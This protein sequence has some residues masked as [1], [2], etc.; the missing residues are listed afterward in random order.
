M[1]ELPF[2]G[3]V[4]Y[5]K[6]L[7]LLLSKKT[8]T[9]A[10][11][12]GRRWIGKSRLI[13]EFAKDYI[14]LEFVGLAPAEGVTAQHQ[15]EA[16]AKQLENYFNLPPLR[17]D[18]WNDLFRALSQNVR[19]GRVIIL[20]DEISWLAH[21]DPTFLSKLKNAWDLYFKKNHELILILCGSVSVWIEENILSSTGYFG[22]IPMSIGLDEL[23]L[24]ECNQL[25]QAQQFVGGN[26]EKFQL[27][28]VTG[29]TPYYL[30]QIQPGFTVEQN[31]RNLCFSENALFVDEFDR[32]FNDIFERKAILYK[33]I[34]TLLADGAL[35]YNAIC[36]K[37]NYSRS[38][39]LSSYLNALIIARF[40]SRDFSWNFKNRKTSRLCKY[41]LS[42]NYIRFYLKYIE[43]K[44]ELIKQGLYETIDFMNLPGWYTTM[45]LQFEN[46]VLKNRKLIIE[47]LGINPLHVVAN[48]PYFQR[49]TRGHRG[50]QIDYLIQTRFNNLFVCEIKYSKQPLSKQV[51]DEVKDKIDRLVIPKGFSCFPVL[52][53]VNGVNDNV[54][55]SGFFSKVINVNVLMEESS[56]L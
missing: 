24:A 15:R 40:I 3:R 18:D 16:F 27:L 55:D 36:D 26:Y 44:K 29:G 28:A 1:S 30:E 17:A 10:V 11:I 7:K 50:C 2:I 45:G 39:R 52:I 47:L 54:L 38:G 4:K 9:L 46:I 43:P 13:E 32:I 23:N 42:D 21:D 8:A 56:A 12:N 51:I 14:F 5:L 37:L 25:L 34:I 49:K 33:K 20:L 48:N 31:I 22:R 41:R 6:K 53:H 19:K 35:E